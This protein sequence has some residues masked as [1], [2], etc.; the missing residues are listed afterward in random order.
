[1]EKRKS[2][3]G[4]VFFPGG[5]IITWS[6]QKQ[7][8]VSL[9]SCESEYIA[10]ATGACQGVRLSRL[11]ADLTRSDVKKFSLFIDNKSAL[12]LCKNPVFHERTKHIDTRYHYIKDCVANGVVDVEHVRTDE[13]LADILTKPL[14]RVRFI[15]LRRQLGVVRAGQD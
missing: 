11:L 7:R 2:T 15:E 9:S 5:N 14:G 13:Q 3:T 10:A 8:V 6:S 4:V 12:E 1:M